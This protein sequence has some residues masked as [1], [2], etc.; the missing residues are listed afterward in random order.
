[1]SKRI[2]LKIRFKQRSSLILLGTMILIFFIS[3][4]ALFW[5]AKEVMASPLV[6]SAVD[7]IER[8]YYLTEALYPGTS[9]QKACADGY[10]MA[11]IWEIQDPSGLKY[12]TELGQ[13]RE[14]SGSGPP[15]YR[16]WVRTG[17]MSST[18]STP[19]RGNCGAWSSTGYGSTA[20]LPNTWGAG[21]E[22]LH[23]WNVSTSFCGS[24]NRVW[25]V[26]E[27]PDITDVFLALLLNGGP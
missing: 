25:C 8:Q 13:T 11:S 17:Y 14:D 21:W 16:G 10:D 15:T 9:A 6:P 1:M 18:D 4:I 7:F 20:A 5:G 3:V 19:G 24:S 2:S 26:Q 23:V 12:N 22:D 27:L